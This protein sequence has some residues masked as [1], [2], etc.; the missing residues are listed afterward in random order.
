[1]PKGLSWAGTDDG[2]VQLTRDGGQHWDNVT[3]KAMPE[4]GTVSMIDASPRDAGTA[5]VAVER[6]KMDDFAPYI[7]KTTDFGKTWTK[8]TKG[9]PANNYVHAVRTDPGRPGL[10]F[11]G[12][13]MGVYVS[14][15]DG[16]KWQAM[17]INLPMSPINDL[18]VKNDDLVV[19]THGRSFWVLDNISPLRQFADSIPQEQAHLFTPEPA[20]RMLLEG[21]FFRGSGAVGQNPPSGAV[22]DFWLKESLQKPEMKD[23]ATADASKGDADKDKKEPPKI[24][25]EIV[26]GAGKTVRKFAPKQEE[27]AGGSDDEEDFFSR[28][29]G[30]AKLPMDAGLNRFVWDLRYEGATKVPKAPLWG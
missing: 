23:S 27:G 15:D 1:V 17:Q 11:A 29:G 10:L 3:P 24:T 9:I 25:L 19:A 16:A 14:F 20:S 7:F 26:D 2:L 22:I 12:T 13:E 30:A 5:Y 4:W 6:H 28:G 18:G 8:Q 21:G